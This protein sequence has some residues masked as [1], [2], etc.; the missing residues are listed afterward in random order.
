MNVLPGD[1][2]MFAINVGKLPPNHTVPRPRENYAALRLDFLL[3][4]VVLVSR[5][6]L[7]AISHYDSS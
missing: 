3:K 1:G 2:D 7:I 4:F 5:R 6:V